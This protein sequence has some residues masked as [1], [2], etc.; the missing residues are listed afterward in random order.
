M[1]KLRNVMLQQW[2][3]AATDKF[4]LW[5]QGD[6]TTVAVYKWIIDTVIQYGSVL[7]SHPN[8]LH[9]R[10]SVM[11]QDMDMV[12]SSL[13]P[14][15]CSYIFTLLSLILAPLVLHITMYTLVQIL[16]NMSV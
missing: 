2:T 5:V 15:A 4:V 8:M 13:H 10:Q 9:V 16:H 1:L 14:H 3:G 11:G 12:A 6:S 7:Q